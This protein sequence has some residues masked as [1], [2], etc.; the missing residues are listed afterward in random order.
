MICAGV[1]WEGIRLEA[2]YRHLW[3]AWDT[4]PDFRLS[5]GGPFVGL[6]ARF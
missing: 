5:M 3:A 4:D 1:S 6:S 2:G